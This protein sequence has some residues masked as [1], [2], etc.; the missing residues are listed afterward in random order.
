MFSISFAILQHWESVSQIK[1]TNIIFLLHNQNEIILSTLNFPVP[2]PFQ[3]T[4][5]AVYN[6][7]E[8]SFLGEQGLHDLVIIS[9]F[10]CYCWSTRRGAKSEHIT[11]CFKLSFGYSS[12][13]YH[14]GNINCYK[15]L[16]AAL[17]MFLVQL[18]NGILDFT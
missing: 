2:F 1:V 6:L 3:L 14:Q 17:D 4:I 11:F 15:T 18:K 13:L 9:W 12:P 7:W 16:D 5:T 8:S 10:Q